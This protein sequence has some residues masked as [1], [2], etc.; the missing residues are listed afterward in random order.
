MIILRLLNLWVFLIL[1]PCKADVLKVRLQMQ[2]VGQKGSL[3]GMVGEALYSVLLGY[4][5]I[6]IMNYWVFSCCNV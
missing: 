2:L 6:F 3:T 1:Q 4:W 5:I